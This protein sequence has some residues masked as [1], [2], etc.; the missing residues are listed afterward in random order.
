[1]NE[2]KTYSAAQSL[3]ISELVNHHG[4]DPSQINFD[5]DDINPIFDY[6]A[7]SSLSLKLTDI[8][9][10]ECE[11]ILRDREAGFVQASCKV[12]LPDGRS[13]TVEGS[14]ELGE[15]FANGDKIES[16]QTAEAVAQSRASRLGIRSVGINLYHAHQRYLQTGTIANGHDRHDP[17]KPIYAEIHMLA[18]NLEMIVAG[19]KT[20]YRN[21]I[22]AAYEGRTS[23]VDLDDLEIQRFLTT[24]RAMD[25]VR[26][27]RLEARKAA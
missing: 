18:E 17:R 7:I 5:G 9:D 20:E 2:Q 8:K 22:A 6:T 19:D 11:I 10:I 26:R 14:A 16:M 15:T 21:F 25:R 27:V 13:R 3:L 23:A 12:T 24:L 4:L 1:M